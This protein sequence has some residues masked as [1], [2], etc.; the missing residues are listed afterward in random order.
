MDAY[1]VDIKRLLRFCLQT[2]G[3]AFT[4]CYKV[5]ATKYQDDSKCLGDTE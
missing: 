2:V 4:P 3:M 5:Y 1:Y